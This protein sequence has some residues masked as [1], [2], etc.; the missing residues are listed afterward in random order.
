MPK[1]NPDT[2][3]WNVDDKKE[4]YSNAKYVVTNIVGHSGG[5]I[6]RFECETR[7]GAKIIIKHKYCRP[8]LHITIEDNDST[9]RI[10]IECTPY[11]EYWDWIEMV[12]RVPDSIV[13]EDSI[14]METDIKDRRME[15]RANP[16]T[17]KKKVR[18]LITQ[19]SKGESIDIDDLT[20]PYND[21]NTIDNAVIKW[22]NYTTY[23]S[24]YSSTTKKDM[25]TANIIIL[26]Y[27]DD[28]CTQDDVINKINELEH[29]YFK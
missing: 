14:D 26:K 7:C 1:Y 8:V 27:L 10:N 4:E 15:L 9:E 11:G 25:R 21:Y 17:K 13:F 6:D 5:G 19:Q 12:Y 29:K 2:S 18:T 3:H 23:Y 22:L 16:L 28:K 20:V 24:E